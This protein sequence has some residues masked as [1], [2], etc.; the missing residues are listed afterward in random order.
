MY[1]C[2]ELTYVTDAPG[3]TFYQRLNPKFDMKYK[4]V[5]KVL[6]DKLNTVD[7]SVLI[8]SPYLIATKKSN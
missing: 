7:K 4:F 3:A 6:F 8:S 2:P 5:R 1:V